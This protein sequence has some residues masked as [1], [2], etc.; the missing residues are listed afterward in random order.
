MIRRE[1]PG[2]RAYAAQGRQQVIQR[3]RY[4]LSRLA[5]EFNYPEDILRGVHSHLHVLMDDWAKDS[6]TIT[7]VQTESPAATAPAGV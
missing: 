2:L 1:G 5:E 7:L 6:D 4:E 3:G